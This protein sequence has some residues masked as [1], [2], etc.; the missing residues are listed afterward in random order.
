MKSVL[1]TVL[2]A[3]SIQLA[4][5]GSLSA[6]DVNQKWGKVS[7]EEMAM[8]VYPKDTS[9][10]A[11]VLYQQRSSN[12]EYRSTSGFR[13]NHFVTMRIKI[14]RTEGK[15][16][17]TVIIPYYYRSGGDRET[18]TGVEGWTYN[19]V[20]GKQV[21]TKLSKEY[22][23]DEEINSRFHQL[24]FSFPDVKVGSVI[25]Y[26]YMQ[27][28]DEVYYLPDWDIQRDIP[29]L[30]SAFKINIPEYFEHNIAVK[31]FELLDIKESSEGTQFNL[32][33]DDGGSPVIIAC[34]TRVIQCV[35]QDI[36][37]LRD[38]DYVWCLDDYLSGVRF[39]LSGTRFPN[40]T[41]KP[42]TQ[43]WS[44]LE[45]T[46]W[47]ETDMP[48]FL[49]TPNPWKA[50]TAKL[51]ENV[52][53]EKEKIDLLFDFVKKHVRWN[54]NYALIGANPKEA[55]KSGIGSNAQINFL[56]MSVLRDAGLDTYPVLLSRR[57]NGRLPMTHPSIT[58]LNTFVVA[59]VT[60]D[61]SIYYMDGSSKFG[62]INVLPPNL[63][64]HNARVF[65]DRT[66]D[67]WVNLNKLEKNFEISNIQASIDKDGLFS[68]TR[69][70]FYSNQLAYDYKSRFASAKD[71]VDFIKQ[72]QNK[73][74]VVIDS[75]N[76]VGK[77]PM[78]AKVEE[79]MVF[80]KQLELSGSYIYVN[81]MVFKHMTENKFTQT[82]RKLPI[83]FPYPVGYQ[84]ICS[85]Q[86]PDDYQVEELPKSVKYVLTG[87]KA[88]CQ[89]LAQ[90]TGN[91]VVFKYAFQVLQT[92]Y[93]ETDYSILQE[94]FGQAV[95][96]NNEML[97]L[98]KKA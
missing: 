60:K 52:T 93:P 39:E 73:H 45:K 92:I 28:T 49:K 55:V 44:G 8:T 26:K 35:A 34:R 67:K 56:V 16:E 84:T 23:F 2:L 32:G 95:A 24:K 50:E 17:G 46:I 25:E 5:A 18:I 74:D 97:V 62:G 54:E 37:A 79:R 77:E 81:P 96:K 48:L 47:E 70:T 38:E 65:D 42:F 36:P 1:L 69:T 85:I 13:I 29:V 27:S 15:D 83:E 64:V 86:I 90:Q 87:N 57:N 78:S 98:K 66:S 53:N 22:M 20:D 41:Y 6:Y 80:N 71:S 58:K 89:F 94:F 88:I 76:V 12:F 82:E 72:I 40:T 68:G 31:G 75:F 10:K 43:S 51:I 61:S 9:A 3:F 63:L 33:N 11:V 21:K 91:T 4:H 7:D 59:A 19:L 14:L 30:N